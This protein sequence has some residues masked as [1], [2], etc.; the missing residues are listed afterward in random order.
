MRQSIRRQVDAGRLNPDAA[1]DLHTKVDAVAKEIAEGDPDQAK[2]QLKKLREKLDELRR[3]GKLTADGY[4]ALT[5]DADRIAAN[6][7]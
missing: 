4:D 3:D 7:R 5:A 2:D 1:R 6:L